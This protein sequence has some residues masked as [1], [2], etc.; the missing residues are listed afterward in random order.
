[1]P[2]LWLG[3]LAAGCYKEGIGV[4]DLM[5][6]FNLALEKPWQIFWTPYTLKAMLLALLLYGFALAMYFSAKE[7][8]RPGEEHG[9]AK[10]GSARELNAKYRDKHPEQNTILSQN[11]RMG[12]NGKKHRRNLLQ[13]VIGGSGSGKSEIKR[14]A[15][16]IGNQKTDISK[17]MCM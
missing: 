17:C 12:L 2:V 6:R 9:S 15:E 4:F 3:A 11:I 7:N 10:W 5:S 13:I 16:N 1:M 8:R 14:A